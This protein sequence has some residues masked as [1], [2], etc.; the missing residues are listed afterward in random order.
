MAGSAILRAVS[1]N[2]MSLVGDRADDVSQELQ[3]CGLVLLQGTCRRTRDSVAKFVQCS[4]IHFCF[5]YGDIRT[6]FCKANKSTGVSI[7]LHSRQFSERKFV[8]VF[9]IF[10]LAVTCLPMT[11]S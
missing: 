1:W 2:P 8:S 6:G 3:N 4:H 9:D 10:Q 5:G 11:V 7:F